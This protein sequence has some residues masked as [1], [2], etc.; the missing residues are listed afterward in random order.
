MRH[1]DALRRA[2]AGVVVA[3]VGL[4][5]VVL[6]SS[7]AAAHA[8]LVG[9]DPQDGSV[10][11][12]PPTELVLTFNEPVRGVPDGT[13]ILAA[14]GTPLEVAVA[15]V[16]DTLVLTPASV[17]ADGT[18]VV[19]WR[20]ISLDT[21]PVAG[22]FTFSVGEPSATSVAASVPEP[23]TALVVAR[24]AGQ[25]LL[26]VAVLGV[27]GLVVFEL[28]VLQAS[29]GAMPVLRRRLHVTRAAGAA[30]AAATA[31]LTVPLTVAW[32]AGGGLDALARAGTW[33]GGLTS[34]TAVAS[35]LA[36]VGV[37]VATVAARRAGHDARRAWPAG[38]ATA[39][40]AAALGS[41]LVVGHTRTFGPGWLVL[42]A[43]ALH[44][45]TGAV[46]LGGVVGLVATLSRSAGV[47][48]RRAAA[49][50]ARFSALG[51]WL[52]A[53]LALT[54]TVLGWRVVGTLEAL[55][56]SGYGRT[57]LVKVAVAVVI[58]GIA[59]Y[60][61]FRL[62]PAVRSAAEAGA[63]RGATADASRRTL[64]RTVAGEAALLGLV[65]AATG[66]LVSQQPP[67][68]AVSAQ[69]AAGTAAQVVETAVPLGDGTLR[70]RVS[71]GR[72][73]VNALELE[74]LD[75]EGAPIEPVETPQVAVSLPA[76]GL[77]P[78]TR[79]LT[80]TGPG[81]YEA[82]LDLPLPGAWELEVSVRTSKYDNPIARIPVEVT[83]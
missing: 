10:V 30:L 22:A 41:L 60:N 28:L 64:R 62:V 12:A 73:G 13:T 61:R 59:A 53:A 69:A 75:A 48:P 11:D 26:Y 72:A 19:S 31:V 40:A 49:T 39:S 44:V 21:H 55:V 68:A 14:D 32:Q 35:L 37:V 83:P 82:T 25:A 5:L 70:A 54:G 20:V 51:A 24:A 16:D 4:L 42:G 8:V 38:V 71:P 6:A 76:V 65:L 9:T 29:P 34:D 74:V 63:V 1:P 50:V 52:V 17:L 58:V 7:P 78:L 2:G 27:T 43:D 67:A 66:A 56:T 79:P 77:G 47:D 57:L 33:T 15:A 3:V 18:Y 81:R 80:A 36:V 23:T 46:W 45:A